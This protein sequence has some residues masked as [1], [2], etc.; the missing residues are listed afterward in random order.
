ME[1]RARTYLVKA[2]DVEDGGLKLQVEELRLKGWIGSPAGGLL[3]FGFMFNT[4]LSFMV[5]ME[6]DERTIEPGVI[7][8]S[9][10]IDFI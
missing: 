3:L 9:S 6:S 8:G 2:L 7:L 4:S 1:R 5:A 10:S